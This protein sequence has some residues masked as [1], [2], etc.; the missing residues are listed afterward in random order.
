VTAPPTSPAGP[1][2]ERASSAEDPVAKLLRPTVVLPILA[3]VVILAIVLSPDI[4][5][6]AV[7]LRLTSYLAGPASAKGLYETTGR[8]GWQTQR[9]IT[10]FAGPLDTTAVYAVLG[11]PEQMTTGESHALLDAVRRGAGLVYVV[12][13]GP[14]VDSLPL[15]HSESGRNLAKAPESDTVGCRRDEFPT[16]LLW[17]AAGVHLYYLVDT[18][19]DTLPHLHLPGDT[20]V[21]LSVSDSGQELA[22]A[23]IGYPLGRGRVVA[24]SDPDAL[25]NDVIRVCR[26]NVGPRIIAAI[27]YASQGR[28]PPLVFDEYH[29]GYGTHADITAA[30]MHF[31]RWHPIGHTI[32]Q[33]LVG[34]LILVLALGV[35]A[36]APRGFPRIERRSPLEHVDALARAYEQINA[37]QTAVARLVRGLRRRHDRSGWSLRAAAAAG[38]PTG[39]DDR[40]LTAVAASHPQLAGDVKRIMA[41]EHATVPPAEL[42]NISAAVDRIDQAFPA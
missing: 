38:Q 26:F 41:A 32:L 18:L 16:T 42:L 14:L 5:N 4:A 31:L 13:D 20:A 6:T 28:R 19:K 36:I 21:F 11:G 7:D 12:Q 33:L 25:R 39:A 24:V 2:G 8:L 9:R 29:E 17:L 40:F 27:D 35:R 37:T 22:P 34:G 15:R 30:V 23:V 1:P 3:T 10:P